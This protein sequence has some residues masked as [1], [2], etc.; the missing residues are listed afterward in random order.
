MSR[1][2][3]KTTRAAQTRAATLREPQFDPHSELGRLELPDTVIAPRG[4]RYEWKR[5][6][7]FGKPDGANISRLKAEGWVPV[8]AD[9]HPELS[10]VLWPG[11]SAAQHTS[12]L[13]EGLILCERAESI[14]RAVEDRIARETQQITRTEQAKLGQSEDER[15]FPR[16]VPF[17][18]TDVTRPDGSPVARPAQRPA[19]GAKPRSAIPTSGEPFAAE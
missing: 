13:R 19:R 17:L 11:E 3:T 10:P 12:V 9:R 4:M 1:S 18:Q 8:P 15:N 5:M 2:R 16:M 6:E 7:T 14:C